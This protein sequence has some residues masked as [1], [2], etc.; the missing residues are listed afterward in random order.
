VRSP[1]LAGLGDAGLHPLL[2]DL[3]LEFREDDEH[4]R[5]GRKRADGD[6]PEQIN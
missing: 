5:R 1:F 3:A 2:Q 6:K 4:A